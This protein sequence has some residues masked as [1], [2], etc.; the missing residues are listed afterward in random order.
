VEIVTGG[1]GETGKTVT[2][3][4]QR[5][6]DGMWLQAGG[7][8]WG[9][10]DPDS[11]AVNTMG[12][13]DTTNLP[14]LY[15]YAIPD[16]QLGHDAGMEGYLFRISEP[17]T[18]LLE[19]VKVDTTR[20]SAWDDVRADHTTAGTFGEGVGVD[21]IAT[22]A[23]DAAALATDAVNEIVDQVWNEVL[24]PAHIIPGTAGKALL[25]TGALPD[26]NDIADQVWRENINNHSGF[27]NSTAEALAGIDGP[28]IASLVWEEDKTLHNNP[29]TMGELL[30]AA[31]AG[32]DAAT[33]ADA[34]WNE[35]A[36]DHV[37]STSFG[38][39]LHITGSMSH[40]NHRMKSPVYDPDGRLLSANLVSYPSGAAAAA[41]SGAIATVALTMT[42]DTEGNL[43]SVLGE[44]L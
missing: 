44:K 16:P 7:G 25:D 9:A 15:Q 22:D 32:A 13:P 1:G 30:N 11:G 2:L 40:L 18:A 38:G 39:L 21:S 14:G 6:S 3:A 20:R 17:T 5:L 23:V 10:T 27:A 35:P 19:Y 4:V 41:D 37:S 36:A 34:V 33:I 43:E 28:T 12:E 29:N 26:V 24:S 42:Y 31:G 8:S